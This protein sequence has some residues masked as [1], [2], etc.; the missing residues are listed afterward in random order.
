MA[1]DGSER[2]AKDALSKLL[3]MGMVEDYQ[4]EFEMLIKRVTIPESLLKSF[5]ISGLKLNLQCLLL[6]SNLKTLDEAFSLARAAET[7]FAN[8]DI[9][10]FLRSNPSTLGEDFFKA[11]ITE[12]RFEI[13][14]KEDKE[15][16]VEK[17]IDVILPLQGEFA[18]PKAKGSLNADE[19]IGVEE[20]VGGGEALGIGEDDDLGDAATDG[21]DDEVE[22]G[23][24]S[25]LN[26]LIGHG[27]S[28]SLQ[29]GEKP[30]RGMFMCS[31]TMAARIILFD[32]TSSKYCVYLPTLRRCLR[33]ILAEVKLFC[34]RT[35]V[36]M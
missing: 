8:L 15:H 32:P 24:I 36:P 20:V 11:R 22:S 9:L 31:S 5:Y 33:F 34:V 14:A 17:K 23:D 21:G 13:I 19:Y 7:R 2:D 35:C 29:L 16:I 10:E 6:R 30:A 1:S 27:S 3:Q 12:A 4:Q 18:S 25:I 28:R 26:S